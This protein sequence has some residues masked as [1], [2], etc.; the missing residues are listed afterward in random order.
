VQVWD[1]RGV[2]VGSLEGHDGGVWSLIAYQLPPVPEGQ[3]HIVTGD[4]QG[5]VRIFGGADCAIQVTIRAHEAPVTALVVY[6]Q[7][8]A[9]LRL[10]S[11]ARDGTVEVRLGAIEIQQY[12]PSRPPVYEFIPGHSQE[13]GH[14]D[15][16]LFL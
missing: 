11:G 1:S 14:L 10:A 6:N 3:S 16:L 8:N 2:R 12:N 13:F 4:G 7:P 9:G 5:C 15:P